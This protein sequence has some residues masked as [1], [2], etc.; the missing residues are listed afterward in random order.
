LETHNFFKSEARLFLE[1]AA[2]YLVPM[3]MKLRLILDNKGFC[4]MVLIGMVETDAVPCAYFEGNR[5]T[6][7]TRGF[8]QILEMELGIAK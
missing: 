2:G 1:D 8:E 3:V 4:Q 6:S 7:M 5:I